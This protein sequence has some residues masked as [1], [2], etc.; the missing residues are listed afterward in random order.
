MHWGARRS[1]VAEIGPNNVL[2]TSSR[3]SDWLRDEKGIMSR[4]AHYPPPKKLSGRVV[5]VI[6]RHPGDCLFPTRQISCLAKPLLAQPGRRR[7]DALNAG[8]DFTVAPVG[9]KVS[10]YQVLSQ[11]VKDLRLLAGRKSG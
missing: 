11:I 5:S 9:A 10:L 4:S 8:P 7:R 2:A 1:A 6:A 3:Y